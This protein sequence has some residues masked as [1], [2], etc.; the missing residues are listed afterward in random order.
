MFTLTS[1][2]EC[3]PL[4]HESTSSLPN[5]WIH[6]SEHCEGGQLPSPPTAAYMLLPVHRLSLRGALQSGRMSS[7]LARRVWNDGRTQLILLCPRARQ[8]SAASAS[9][10]RS[11]EQLARTSSSKLVS[12]GSLMPWLPQ[13][14]PSSRPAWASTDDGDQY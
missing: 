5:C 2:C 6:K 12:C 1:L 14:H 3:L 4:R 13:D 9:A 11:M 10:L 8:A 7:A